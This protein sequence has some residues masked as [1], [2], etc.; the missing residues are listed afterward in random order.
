MIWRSS[1]HSLC[2]EE[3]PTALTIQLLY[4]LQAQLPILQAPMAG[5]ATPAMAAAVSNA[6]ASGA[7]GLQPGG[8]RTSH[9]RDAAS[10]LRSFQRE[11]FCH[12]RPQRGRALEAAWIQRMAS[13]FARLEAEPPTELRNLYTSFRDTDAYLEL[14]LQVRPRVVSFHLG[15]PRPGQI[16]A[17]HAAGLVLT[18]TS[19]AEARAI[20]TAG[21]HA[22]V[23]QGWKVGK[24]HGL[25]EPA[26]P[27]ARLSTS[28]LLRALVTEAS[29]SV[30]AAGGIMDGRDIGRMLERGAA[31]AQLGTP[32]IGCLESAAD[33]GYRDRLA[34]GDHTVMTP[35]ISGARPAASAAPSSNGPRMLHPLPYRPVGSRT[36]SPEWA[37]WRPSSKN[38]P[39]IPRP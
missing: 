39:A 22:V 3:P 37:S 9:H 11:L 19:P 20:E 31:A 10:D 28:D 38:H 33:A 4:L 29:L 17:L 14:V 35:A 1:W 16:E 15:L 8:C 25:F 6:S 5:V 32:F 18:G 12:A 7:V 36:R 30:I 13:L 24:H 21:F 34:L 26:G 2:R 27:D 23:A